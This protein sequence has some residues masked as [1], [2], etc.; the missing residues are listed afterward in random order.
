MLIKALSRKQGIT[1]YQRASLMVLFVG[2]ISLVVMYSSEVKNQEKLQ[3]KENEYQQLMMLGN[4]ARSE[5]NIMN[6]IDLELAKEVNSGLVDIRIKS[7]DQLFEILNEVAELTTEFDEQIV[8]FKATIT[9]HQKR[10]A[11]LSTADQKTIQEIIQ[12]DAALIEELDLELMEGGKTIARLVETIESSKSALNMKL[13]IGISIVFLIIL[14]IN[15]LIQSMVKTSIKFV[16]EKCTDVSDALKSGQ[17]TL[18]DSTPQAFKEMC[19]I[20]NSFNELEGVINSLLKT[21]QELSFEMENAAE[22]T[23][24][25]GDQNATSIKI[26]S[27]R[28]KNLVVNN[29]EVTSLA[30]QLEQSTDIV[31]SEISNGTTKTDSSYQLAQELS[32]EAIHVNERMSVDANSAQELTEKSLS[33]DNIIQ[34][35]L[36]ISDQTNLL[37]LNAAIEA[38]RAGEAGRGFAVV[39]DEVRQ[40]AKNTANATQEIQTL[41]SGLGTGI[42]ELST[43]INK[44][45]ISIEQM[46]ENVS[47]V[48][49]NLNQLKE[50]FNRIEQSNNETLGMV[51]NQ[52]ALTQAGHVILTDLNSESDELNFNTGQSNSEIFDLIQHSQQLQGVVRQYKQHQG[53]EVSAEKINLEAKP[54]SDKEDSVDFF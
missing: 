40:L 36:S 49:A 30:A 3:L 43:S 13:Y 41:L 53:F 10:L 27:D 21:I 24:L 50:N 52:S 15:F 4:Q 54:K 14:G 16:E 12:Q 7:I 46:N 39:A 9:D 34:T 33:A 25:V 47:T 29:E 18:N 28:I 26:Q 5:F 2:F 6:S 11:K 51:Q 31:S 38:A 32:Q 23:N 1:I 19:V 20:N 45:Q 35:I 37:A 42:K 17:F 22:R 44:N 48:E 8:Y